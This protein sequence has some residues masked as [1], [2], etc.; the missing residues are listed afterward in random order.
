MKISTILLFIG[1]LILKQ[2]LV[3][4]AQSGDIEPL[5]IPALVVQQ[6][7][8]EEPRRYPKLFR[9][10]QHDSDEPEVRYALTIREEHPPSGVPPATW[11]HALR[12]LYATDGGQLII[13]NVGLTSAELQKII[14]S[15]SSV[16]TSKVQVLDIT[17]NKL[18]VVPLA[19]TCFSHIKSIVLDPTVRIPTRFRRH[20]H[21]F[22][23][24]A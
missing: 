8:D 21:I 2:Q 17:K 22:K 16:I 20:M 1:C 14:L 18:T 7:V 13:S 15:L 5:K 23:Y 9:A 24:T 3:A 11:A 4:M 10:I 19:I 6:V 12:S